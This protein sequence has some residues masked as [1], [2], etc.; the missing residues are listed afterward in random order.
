MRLKTLL[1]LPLLVASLQAAS[2]SDLS[3]T[4][5]NNDTEYK[6]TSCNTSATGILEIPNT[7]LGL[8]VTRIATLAFF[9]CLSLTRI[10]IPNSITDIEEDAFTNTGTTSIESL[11]T[12]PPTLYRNV[13]VSQSY[14]G[15]TELTVPIGTRE[16]YLAAGNGDTY[17]GYTV[18][19]TINNS[20]DDASY[21]WGLV[22][23]YYGDKEGAYLGDDVDVSSDGKLFLSSTSKGFVLL[24]LNAQ[25][26]FVN[27]GEDNTEYFG[28]L[29]STR[30]NVQVD[31]GSEGKFIATNYR[32]NAPDNVNLHRS[33]ICTFWHYSDNNLNLINNVTAEYKDPY[34]GDPQS[35]RDYAYGIVNSLSDDGDRLLLGSSV[36]QFNLPR[37]NPAQNYA[38]IR[39]YTITDQNW[40]EINKYI[41]D[42]NYRSINWYQTG[43]DIYPNPSQSSS[44]NKT[45]NAKLSGDGNT[46]VYSDISSDR[47]L[48]RVY[49]L[50]QNG[51]E[52]SWEQKGQELSGLYDGDN[53]FICDIS[54]D[55]SLIVI[56]SSGYD[57]RSSEGSLPLNN[58]G[59]I[60]TYTF[61][62]ASNLWEEIGTP[63]YGAEN[64][65]IGTKISLSGDGQILASASSLGIGIYSLNDDSNW[66]L[67]QIIEDNDT[68]FPD[69]SLDYKATTLLVGNQRQSA[70]S[71]GCIDVYKNQL[72]QTDFDL[73][74]ISDHDE[75]VIY[76]TSINNR[77]SNSDGLNDGTAVSLGINPN[78]DY[79]QIISY[80]SNNSA[81][82]NIPT[83]DY[84]L[85][86]YS[87]AV[88][89]SRTLGQQDVTG[90]PSQYGLFT[91][92]DLSDAQSSSR[93]AGQLDVTG[94]PSQYGLFT[95]SDLNE[96]QSSTRA[97]GQQD[98][99]SSPSDYNLMGAEGVF[100]MRV[101]QPGISTN[102]D[103]ASMNF[104]IQSSNDLQDWNNEETIRREY[105]MPS[106]KNF[107]RVSVVPEIEPEPEPVVLT[108]I[109]TDTYGDR[110]V[111][112]ESNNLYVN[113][114]N[115]PL[116]KDGVNVKLDT[117]P[118]WSFYAIESHRGRYY[119]FL[120]KNNQNLLIQ[121]GLDGNYLSTSNVSS[122]LLT[123]YVNILG[124]SL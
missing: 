56:G 99:I 45:Y 101:S 82:F 54:Y 93:S 43:N 109:A 21:T 78:D 31:I 106:D 13:I 112:D 63:L 17:G 29:Q 117:F 79:S 115:T 75:V 11:A 113:D 111:Y 46:Y 68:P 65:Q 103:K 122:A 88:T 9:R 123:Y 83:G 114:E 71:Y 39:K 23:T 77:D 108:T 110:L 27:L 55:G 44:T 20:D 97:A 14:N 51:Y 92:S 38:T 1:T 49:K 120:K 118:G 57:W 34:Y 12:I 16:L 81:D 72:I 22:G 119:C 7:Y 30:F 90:N 52:F 4:L 3:F 19:E 94:N 33:G 98:V 102:G 8:P 96:A 32:Y 95:S 6:L 116:M 58:S 53:S 24:E 91:S 84:S 42:T 67:T 41:P 35:V 107:M 64:Q 86:E 74:G 121:F 62:N 50:V 70:T 89:A 76:K 85:E 59:K 100:D 66:I 26:E 36:T 105:T 60:S 25:N 2:T 18:V 37:H 69:L 80:I 28:N 73:D 48:V 87:S 15:T 104:T 10:V 5:I 61:N 47:G 40:I 124:Q